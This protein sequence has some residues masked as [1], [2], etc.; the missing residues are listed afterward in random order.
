MPAKKKTP[1]KSSGPDD[2]SGNVSSSAP[3]AAGA[4]DHK[5]NDEQESEVSFGS[6]NEIEANEFLDRIEIMYEKQHGLSPVGASH[7]SKEAREAF[8]EM[9][10][11]LRT[12][13]YH[14]DA[15]VAVVDL[16]I[17]GVNK[18]SLMQQLPA[19]SKSTLSSTDIVR[20]SATENSAVQAK[21]KSIRETPIPSVEE[22][23]RQLK[24]QVSENGR[25][26]RQ[27]FGAE[28]NA[29]LQS[30]LRSIPSHVGLKA[31]TFPAIDKLI[32][33]TSTGIMTSL[34]NANPLSAAQMAFSLPP[35]LQS[36]G[37]HST[38]EV[39]DARDVLHPPISGLADNEKSA[40]FTSLQTS[41]QAD[42]T[43]FESVV[44]SLKGR[45]SKFSSMEKVGSLTGGLN[46]SLYFNE[47]IPHNISLDL[48]KTASISLLTAIRPHLMVPTKFIESMIILNELVL[49]LLKFFK[50]V[51]KAFP[52]L[53]IG[54]A[55]KLDQALSVAP[56][57]AGNSRSYVHIYE[58]YAHL[59]MDVASLR[60][61]PYMSQEISK[62]ISSSGTSSGGSHVLVGRVYNYK[63]Q[64]DMALHEQILKYNKLVT[65][66]IEFTP[67]PK[68]MP[69]STAVHP[70]LDDC[71]TFSILASAL[72]EYL[73][74]LGD[75]ES[76]LVLLDIL[77]NIDLNKISTT[78]QLLELIS[79]HSKSGK[80]QAI[81]VKSSLGMALV[82]SAESSDQGL[83]DKACFS[84]ERTG[85]CSFG[86]ECKYKHS[87]KSASSN[88]NEKPPS[89]FELKG[90]HPKLSPVDILKIDMYFDKTATLQAY[91]HGASEELGLPYKIGKIFKFVRIPGRDDTG[92]S[93][94]G[95]L[96]INAS[97]LPKIPEVEN[98]LSDVHRLA[99]QVSALTDE[100]K[101]IPF[102]TNR[103]KQIPISM[104]SGPEWSSKGDKGLPQRNS[105]GF[106]GVKGFSGGS[107]DFGFKHDSGSNYGSN[108]KGSNYGGSSY[109]KGSGKGFSG[110]G[111]QF[112][113]DNSGRGKGYSA[114]SREGDR[115]KG[116]SFLS[117]AEVVPPTPSPD[118]PHPPP[119]CLQGPV[120]QQS[121]IETLQQAMR[122]L[123]SQPSQPSHASM[124]AKGSQS[125][126]Y[127][128][129]Y[130]DGSF[131]RMQ[132]YAPDSS[133]YAPQGA[134]FDETSGKSFW[135]QGSQYNGSNN[136]KGGSGFG[137]HQYRGAGVPGKGG[138]HDGGYN[139]SC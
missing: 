20:F 110:R 123:L 10:P 46:R 72:V 18:V 131:D 3:I 49:L 1:K 77:H 53:F 85:S 8:V 117:A 68:G 14:D 137:G 71:C 51:F 80:F 43:G 5:D 24:P 134:P 98:L 102:P 52:S 64:P 63:F 69:Q 107:V 55:D 13:N 135:S 66:A 120:S 108:S 30:L 90:G 139:F 92:G 129:P 132:S 99:K 22:I 105:K 103:P 57:V 32:H 88:P 65:K 19:L 118:W 38:S 76:R 11:R 33:L 83:S 95:Y 100:F 21:L 96:L 40:P 101:Q 61:L 45:S 54:L 29:A 106:K 81:S 79:L 41:L 27:G 31:D 6:I 91:A 9:Y 115:G 126:I 124:G 130:S 16:L 4:D 119:S 12:T 128:P 15:L 39:S 74:I 35:T 121:H 56:H 125:H 23:K 114:Y 87:D 122:M 89:K 17:L 112:G 62:A 86:D 28:L 26:A 93:W 138:P 97:D 25:S 42:Q 109:G 111:P 116:N 94:N 47:E 50:E 67:I 37:A 36:G 59:G 60:F 2:S 84:F 70:A 44:A 58:L 113:K 34:L 104:I 73:Q 75:T 78:T 127:D 82:T 136:G 133:P 48:L 7:I